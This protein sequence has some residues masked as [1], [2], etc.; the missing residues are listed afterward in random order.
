MKIT[1]EKSMIHYNVNPLPNVLNIN[2]YQPISVNSINELQ[3][4]TSFSVC[5][6]E[7][8]Y[9]FWCRNVCSGVKYIFQSKEKC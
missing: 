4:F 2:L 6:K 3:I 8:M 9:K 1:I 5:Y 7:C